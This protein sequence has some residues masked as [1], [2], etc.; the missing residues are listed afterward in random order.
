[1]TAAAAKS[2]TIKPL[3]N[4]PLVGVVRYMDYWPAKEKDGKQYGAQVS[5]KGTWDEQGEG[6]VYLPSVVGDQIIVDG[7]AHQD[8]TKVFQGEQVPQFRWDYAG[9]VSILRREDG[10]KKFTTVTPVEKNGSPPI[11]QGDAHE[12]G[13]GVDTVAQVHGGIPSPR[14][15][16][17]DLQETYDAC[18]KIAAKVWRLDPTDG[19]NTP[20]EWTEL[21]GRAANTLFIEA[22]KRNLPP[23]PKKEAHE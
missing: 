19:M 15:R 11:Q 18:V 1:M 9:R 20:A 7:L 8:G 21:L 2:P 23:P 17:A 6:T 3:T 13:P 22:N 14:Q 12:P 4:V 10:Q 16:W 5:L